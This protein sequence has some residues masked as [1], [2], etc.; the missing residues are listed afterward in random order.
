[1]K[2]K[3]EFFE[4]IKHYMTLA[5]TSLET[6]RRVVENNLKNGLMPY[7]KRYLGTFKNHFSTIGLCGMNEAC[8]NLLKKDITSPEGKQLTI[9]TLKFMREKVR[10]FQQETGSLYNLEATPAESTAY[11]FAK[12]DKKMYPDIYTSGTPEMPYLTNSTQLP[13]GYTDDVVLALE[14]PERC[15]AAV[16]WRDH[17]STRSWGRG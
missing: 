9:D 3:D 15:P 6:K 11:R 13:V 12:L 17:N 5:K 7:T 16:H 14:H 8:M 4:K 1:S 2:D 10:E